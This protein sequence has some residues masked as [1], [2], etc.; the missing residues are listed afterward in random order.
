MIESS[1]SSGAGADEVYVS[2]WKFYRSLGILADAFT[3]WK[4]KSNE[5]DE[6]DGSSYVD[7]KTLPAKTSKK[8]ALA[9]N[10]E[11]HRAMSTAAIAIES[12]ISSKKESKTSRWSVDDTFGKLFVEQ[13]K[14]ILECNFK[15]DLKISLQQMVFRRKRQVNW[16]NSARQGQLPST[17]HTQIHLLRN[18]IQCLH[19]FPRSL[20]FQVWVP[21]KVI[22]VYLAHLDTEKWLNFITLFIFLMFNA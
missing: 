21:N 2:P 4:T 14:L 17:V 22:V 8:L 16:S 13:L 6:D 3:R 12:V 7:T 19:L 5:I 9:Q 18:T 15:D 10:N 11:L 20:H 1:K